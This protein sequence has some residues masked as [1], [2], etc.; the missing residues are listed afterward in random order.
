MTAA[1]A[2]EDPGGGFSVD[3]YKL[4]IYRRA[5]EDSAPLDPFE[6]VESGALMI[7]AADGRIIP[8]T[9]E[10]M[11]PAQVVV[12]E[13]LKQEMRAGRVPKIII[14][15]ARQTGFSTFCAAMV[16]ALSY[17]RPGY[18]AL[19]L[20]DKEENAEYLHNKSKLM[21]AEMERRGMAKYKL[22]A[23]N[24]KLIAWEGSMSSIRLGSAGSPN[25]GIAQTRSCCHFSEVAF[26][27]HP[28]W[29]RIW[30][31]T[32]PSIH[33][34]PYNLVIVESTGNGA[35]GGYYR[36]WN[37]AQR[38]EGGFRPFFFPWFSDPS[39]RLPV[40]RGFA[41]TEEERRLVEQSASDPWG[42][43]DE[44]QIYWR[45]LKLEEFN[46][47]LAR[48]HEAYPASPVEAFQA[49][50]GIV[51]RDLRH[52]LGEWARSN[53]KGRRGYIEAAGPGLMFRE[54]DPGDNAWPVEIF[55]KPRGGV[56]YCAYSD[57]A[58]GLK[59]LGDEPVIVGGERVDT[60]FSTC[61]I[62]RADTREL[63]A[64]M[65]CRYP[66]DVFAVEVMRLLDYYGNP[67]W[68]IELPGAGAGALIGMVQK[69][70]P[71]RLY[72]KKTINPNT[73]AVTVGEIGFR[74]TAESKG[75]LEGIWAGFIRDNPEKL[76]SPRIAEQALTYIRD[77][78]TG[79]SRP[80]SGNFS[81]I[82]LADAGCVMM[83]TT[84]LQRYYRGGSSPEDGLTGQ[85]VP[86]PTTSGG[87]PVDAVRMEWERRRN[88]YLRRCG[89]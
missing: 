71:G 72:R 28:G 89:Q 16:Y 69:E 55:Q 45:R 38:G 59:N 46:N 75:R 67:D 54:A 21:Y 78:R 31:L 36:M 4:A 49:T 73:G 33:P 15:K 27:E 2:M 29:D 56:V 82:L 68:G 13:Y 35:G 19:V 76:G 14:L 52:T 30:A 51:F 7:E 63:V 85:P 64:L 66:V 34:I 80:K 18:Q 61:V 87:L 12:Y 9:P 65:E 60:T 88:D 3:E 48:F 50:G 37:A 70:Y 42:P 84:D 23:S 86:Q 10:T 74:V 47:D 25:I 17:T 6:L 81:D 83:L 58:E 39:Y 79:K 40:P 62:R 41:M 77:P 44:E 11:K 24:K 22:R 53:V 32:S 8:F 43:L 1:L 5:L 26:Y 57:V 20:C